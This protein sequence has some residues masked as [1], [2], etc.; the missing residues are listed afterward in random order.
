MAGV[1]GAGP[2][3]LMSGCRDRRVG[4]K[5]L[6]FPCTDVG[7][8]EARAV[9]GPRLLLLL[10]L[11]TVMLLR[12]LLTPHVRPAAVFIQGHAIC[13]TDIIARVGCSC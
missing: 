9:G 10:L 13:H 3:C 8:V 4:R 2:G 7:L 1:R 11:Q 6:S 12:L 5:R